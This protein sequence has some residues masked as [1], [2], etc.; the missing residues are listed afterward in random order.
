MHWNK[1]IYTALDHSK[2]LQANLPRELKAT[3]SRNPDFG[4]KVW[5]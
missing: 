1:L 2:V 5:V 4:L 3:C